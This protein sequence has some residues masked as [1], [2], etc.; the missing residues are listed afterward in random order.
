MQSRKMCLSRTIHY[1]HVSIAVATIIRVTYKNIRNPNDLSK[2]TSDPLHVTKNVLN[3]LYFHWISAYLLLKSDTIQFFLNTWQLGA[4]CYVV[5]L[6]SVP[7]TTQLQLRQR[8]QQHF[9][10]L[11][12]SLNPSNAWHFDNSWYLAVCKATAFDILLTVHLNIFI[13]ILTNLM[14]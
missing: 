9:T 11:F 1:Q 8:L 13:L 3:F 10:Y 6:H 5:S 12:T 14:N 2:C 7:C 4:L